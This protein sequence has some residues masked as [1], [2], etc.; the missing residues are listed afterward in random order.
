MA[1][2]TQ[3]DRRSVLKGLAGVT[4]TLPILDAMG[5]E[6]RRADHLDDSVR[7]TPP[8]ACRCR[9]RSTG[10]RVE[11]VP[12]GQAEGRTSSSASRPSRSALTATTSASWADCIIPTGQKPIRTCAPTCG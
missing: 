3:I 10:C 11:L 4:L 1:A 7:S 5:E 2:R 6:G 12:D 9:T 8:T